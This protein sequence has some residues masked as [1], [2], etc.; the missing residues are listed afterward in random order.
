MLRD[1]LK[2]NNK[3]SSI[4]NEVFGVLCLSSATL[5]FGLL[6]VFFFFFFC[7]FCFLLKPCF[8]L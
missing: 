4:V 3:V 7:C 2:N 5:K 8:V 6:G 1:A